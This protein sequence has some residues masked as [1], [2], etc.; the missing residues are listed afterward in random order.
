[1]AINVSA[2]YTAATGEEVYVQQGTYDATA[3]ASTQLALVGASLAIL[4]ALAF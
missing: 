4:S 3:S 1:M 2:Y